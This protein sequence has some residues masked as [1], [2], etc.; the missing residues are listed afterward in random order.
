MAQLLDDNARPGTISTGP[1]LSDVS[2]TLLIPLCIRALESER[3]DGVIRDAQAVALVR[4]MQLDPSRVLAFI[5]DA[6]MI[7]LALRAREFDRRTRAYLARSPQAVVVQIGC[8]LDSRFERVDNGEAEWYDLDLPDVIELRRELAGGDAG[9]HHLLACSALDTAWLDTVTVHRPR[10]FLILAEGVLMY[11]TETQVRS[12]V[13]A[14]TECLPG[15]ELVLDA[16]SP[17]LAW[18]TNLRV[19][20]THVGA[21]VDWALKRARD[22]ERWS[23]GIALLDEWYVFGSADP[24]L[25][26]SPRLARAPWVLRLPVFARAWGVFQYRLGGSALHGAGL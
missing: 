12:L 17:F 2:E 14:L 10:P 6:T 19:T 7:A 3:P 26:Q 16:F 18:A 21:R 15:A 1:A 11:F 9:R 13:L 8:G 24:R 4:R 25:L 5:D 20:L 22:L 23:R